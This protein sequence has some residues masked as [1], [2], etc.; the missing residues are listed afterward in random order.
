MKDDHGN[1]SSAHGMPHGASEGTIKEV[2]SQIK[3][4]GD[5]KVSH[6]YMKNVKNQLRLVFWETTAGC[7]L[8]C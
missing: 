8:E 2:Y 5:S 6:Q 7:N 3:G 4:H 1:G